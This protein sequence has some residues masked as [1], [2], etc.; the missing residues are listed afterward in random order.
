MRL[1]NV[2]SML[3]LVLVLVM[4]TEAFETTKDAKNGVVTPD[5]RSLLGFAADQEERRFGGPATGTDHSNSHAWENFKAW[6]KKT[7][8]FWRK[9]EQKRRLRS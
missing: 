1:V 8:F 5:A 9:W 6:F 3:G 7:F 2:W 4:V